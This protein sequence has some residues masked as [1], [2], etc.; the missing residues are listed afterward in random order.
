MNRNEKRYLERLK[1]GGKITKDKFEHFNPKVDSKDTVS[2]GGSF[3]A[4]FTIRLIRNSNNIAL[5]LPV[6]FLGFAQASSGYRDVITLPAGATLA[7]TG[8]TQNALPD[9]YRFTYT[10]GADVDTIDV[11]CSEIQYPSFLQNSAVDRYRINN[12]RYMISNETVQAQFSEVLSFE[13]NAIFGKDTSN[14]LTPST[15]INPMDQRRISS[16]FQ[17]A[18]VWIKKNVCLLTFRL[19]LSRLK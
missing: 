18:W 4:S 3:K 5:A 1:N 10:V 7:V 19:L 12:I 16:I 14:P 15:F 11:L 2:P 8:G 17:L 6:A 9:R 13:D